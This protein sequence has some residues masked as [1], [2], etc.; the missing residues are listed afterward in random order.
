MSI[1]TPNNDGKTISFDKKALATALGL[2]QKG[3]KDRMFNLAFKPVWMEAKRLASVRVGDSGKA[4]VTDE[5]LLI[6]VRSFLK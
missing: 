4:T 3:F 1:L 5:D 6:S 2:T